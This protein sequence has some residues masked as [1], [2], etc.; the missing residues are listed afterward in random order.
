MCYIEPTWWIFALSSAVLCGSSHHSPQTH[1]GSTCTVWGPHWSPHINSG[2]S[3]WWHSPGTVWPQSDRGLAE[4]E[5]VGGAPEKKHITHFSW[6]LTFH[7]SRA[8]R[9]LEIS[10]VASAGSFWLAMTLQATV[11]CYLEST[12]IF[13]MSWNISYLVNHSFAPCT[14]TSCTYMKQKETFQCTYSK[15]WGLFEKFLY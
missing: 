5:Q 2:Q 4:L 6:N 12:S 11:G 7:N 10:F 13:K 15:G 1:H 8:A 9:R 3:G 14:C